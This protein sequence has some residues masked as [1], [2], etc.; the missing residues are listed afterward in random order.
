MTGE[1]IQ[2]GMVRL[3]AVIYDCSLTATAEINQINHSQ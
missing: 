2:E 3:T 1:S